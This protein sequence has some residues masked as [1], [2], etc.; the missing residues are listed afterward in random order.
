MIIGWQRCPGRNNYRCIPQWLFCDGKDD[1][2][3]GSDELPEN[4][5]ACDETE[6][7]CKNNRC[8]PKQWKCDF[9]D[10]C[11]DGSDEA[12]E[13]CQNVFRECSES[14]FR[15]VYFLFSLIDIHTDYSI[16]IS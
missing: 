5:P 2:R 16:C 1:C 14:E 15:Y 3:D 10:D 8:I 12:K 6:M 9:S 4:C 11:G 7:K 13:L